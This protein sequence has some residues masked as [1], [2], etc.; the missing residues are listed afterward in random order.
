MKAMNNTEAN[1]SD[2]YNDDN[3]Q[4]SIID[5]AGEKLNRGKDSNQAV[6]VLLFDLTSDGKI[7]NLY[8][9]EQFDYMNQSTC[10]SSLVEDINL[11]IDDDE[12]DTFKR[13]I[14]KD[15]GIKQLINLDSCYYLGKVDHTI[16]FS[17]TYNCYALCVND[18]IKSSEGFKLDMPESEINGKRYSLKKMKFS[19]AIKG[20]CK[21][22]LVLSSCMLLLSYIS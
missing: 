7:N 13:C 18:Y 9:I 15:L 1:K 19:R 5:Y 2:L 21:D 17:K 20:E 11:N 4:F 22:S 16:P 10:L 8:L 6:S 3:F 14:S 12:Y